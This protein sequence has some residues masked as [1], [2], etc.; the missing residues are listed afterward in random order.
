[1]RC[2][3]RSRDAVLNGIVSVGCVMMRRIGACARRPIA[4]GPFQRCETHSARVVG[5]INELHHVKSRGVRGIVVEVGDRRWR[6]L[7]AELNLATL[8]EQATDQEVV[9][10]AGLGAECHVS[11]EDDTTE[12]GQAAHR[13]PAVGGDHR[14]DRRVADPCCD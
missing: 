8:T 10:R 5:L 11:P 12:L 1:M 7:E 6:D 14:R 3:R 9:G 2:D 13:A 4:E